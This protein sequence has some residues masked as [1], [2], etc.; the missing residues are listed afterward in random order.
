MVFTTWAD[1]LSQSFQNIS[2][3]LIAFIP[4]LVIAI[5]IFIVVIATFQ[6]SQ[7]GVANFAHLGGQPAI[8]GYASLFA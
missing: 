8:N 5:I 7:G 3:G 6:P 2:Y 4:N 1:V